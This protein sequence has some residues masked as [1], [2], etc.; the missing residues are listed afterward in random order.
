M[1]KAEVE[2]VCALAEELNEVAPNGLKTGNPI[3]EGPYSMSTV[4]R[5]LFDV[6]MEAIASEGDQ[7]AIRR[8]KRATKHLRTPSG[9]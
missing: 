3:Y 9:R 6:A 8:F 7:A 4:L 2:R 5:M 1:P